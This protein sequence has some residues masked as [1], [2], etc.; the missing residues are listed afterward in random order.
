MPLA[1]LS[2]LAGLHVPVIPFWEVAGRAGAVVPWQMV[3]EVPKL[4]AGVRFGFTVTVK[5]V[6]TAQMPALGVKV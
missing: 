4:N 2:I 1:W 3:N 5:L 6:L